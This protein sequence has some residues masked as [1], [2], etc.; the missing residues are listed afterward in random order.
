MIIF[1]HYILFTPTTNLQDER[2][3]VLGILQTK[4]KFFLSV[5]YFFLGKGFRSCLPKNCVDSL[6]APVFE[7]VDK[8][9]LLMVIRTVCQK[10]YCKNIFVSNKSVADSVFEDMTDIS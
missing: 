2:H 4:I 9:Y 3:Q 7:L 1:I 5:Y 10:I 8:I 6:V